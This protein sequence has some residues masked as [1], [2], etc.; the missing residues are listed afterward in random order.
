MAGGN[1][2]WNRRAGG[3]SGHDINNGGKKEP[4]ITLNRFYVRRICKII[5]PSWDNNH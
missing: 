1:A 3:R 5:L 2:G 4:I